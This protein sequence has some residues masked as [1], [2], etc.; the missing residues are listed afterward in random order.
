MSEQRPQNW[1]LPLRVRFRSPAEQTQREHETAPA[2]GGGQ[3]LRSQVIGA[4][5][6]PDAQRRT[7]QI[8]ELIRLGNIL[9]AE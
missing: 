5:I 7:R 9:R 3:A 2:I 8:K 6:D 1:Y 4:A